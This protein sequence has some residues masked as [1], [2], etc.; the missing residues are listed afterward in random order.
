MRNGDQPVIIEAAINGGATK[1]ANPHVPI[2]PDEH[3]ADILAVLEAGAAIVH[4]H[5]TLAPTDRADRLAEVAGG[6]FRRVLAQRPDA[7]CYPATVWGGPIEERLAH[8]RLL[9]EAE[10]LRVAF[11]DPGSTNLG[12]ADADGLPAPTDFV[13]AHTPR[14]VRWWFDDLIALRLGPMYSIFEPGFLRVPLAYERAGRLPR[15]SFVKLYFSGGG[16]SDGRA[17]AFGMPPLPACLDAYLAMLAGSTVPWAVAVLGGDVI[18]SG[19]ARLALERGG[20][21]RVGL[22]DYVGDDRPTNAEVV[23]RAVALCAEVGRP[24]ASPD[25]AAL[26]LDVPRARSQKGAVA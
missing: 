16:R 26:I 2:S 19:L 3:V 18:E 17:W 11:C 14:E 8:H 15:G 23:A 21:L 5:D 12:A 10:L 1:A 22:E 13:Y 6:V 9:A 24:V 25:E 20:H 4:H 7:L